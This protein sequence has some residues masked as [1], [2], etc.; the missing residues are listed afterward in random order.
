MSDVTKPRA[1]TATIRQPVSPTR[2]PA[3]Y[4]PSPGAYETPLNFGDDAR[5]VYLGEKL[6]YPVD[7]TPGPGHYEDVPLTKTKERL[8]GGKIHEEQ[9]VMVDVNSLRGPNALTYKARAQSPGVRPSATLSAMSNTR[10][11]PIKPF[12]SSLRGKKND[13]RL[14]QS[15][16]KLKETTFN[17]LDNAQKIKAARRGTEIKRKPGTAAAQDFDV[18]SPRVK[19]GVRSSQYSKT[20]ASKTIM[21]QSS[22]KRTTQQYFN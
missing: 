4:T 19:K 18:T 6:K 9:M 10:G 12:N 3:E 7:Q 17:D 20:T 2:R 5:N 16:G 11:S 1:S 13:S 14:M 8:K 21:A 15:I 22:S